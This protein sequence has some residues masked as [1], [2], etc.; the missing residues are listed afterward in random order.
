MKKIILF[1]FIAI[2]F[3]TQA[4]KNILLIGTYT[5]GKSEGVYV[6]S[7]DSN[8]GE[9]VKLSSTKSANPS[10]LAVAPNNKFVYAVNEEKNNN[11]SVGSISAYKFNADSSSLTLINSELSGGE[12]PCYVTVDKTGKWLIAGNYNGGNIAVL[13]I[14]ENGAVGKATLT[15]HYGSS[16]DKVRQTKPHVHCTYLS[17]DNKFLYVPDL[18]LDKTLIYNFDAKTGTISPTKQA[19]AQS[20]TSAGPRHITFSADN[21]FAYL[22]EELSATVNVFKHKKGKL[23]S[24]QKIKATPPAYT[25]AQGSADIHVSPDGHFLYCSNRGASNTITCFRIQ[26]DGKLVFLYNTPSLGIAPRNF[27]FDPTGNFLLVANQKSD[28][29]VIFK[30]DISSGYIADTG[31]R[32]DVGNPVCVKWINGK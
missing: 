19:F 31:K 6:Y 21:K 5:T 14:L 23:S 11:S 17:A 18:G 15:Q 7:F 30:I 3:N 16:T 2:T 20:D 24:I 26:E 12:S 8:T 4:Q 28:N 29:I 10:Y 25:G 1:F 9:T 13:P 27:N 32:V 22:M